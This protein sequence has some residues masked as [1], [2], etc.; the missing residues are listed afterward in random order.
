MAKLLY[1]HKTIKYLF[2]FLLSCLTYQQGLAQ[3]NDSPQLSP[4]ET[5]IYQE[6]KALAQSGKT[7]KSI[8]LFNKLLKIKPDFTEGYLRLGSQYF[9]LQNYTQAKTAFIKAIE[10]NPSFNPEMYY[11]IAQTEKALKNY[12]QAAVYLDQFINTSDNAQK[13]EKAKKMKVNCLFIDHA[14][15]HPVPFHPVGAG[16][17]INTAHSEY[18]PLISVDGQH[19]VFTRNIQNPG[20]FIGQEDIYIA[21]KDS[22]TWINARPMSGVNTVGNEGAFAISGDGYYIVFAACDRRESYGSCDL[23]YSMFM[24]NE[25]TKPVNMGKVVNSV[26]WDSHPTLSADGRTMIFSSR[27]KGSVGGADLWMTQKDEKNS[28][29]TPW[30][31]GSVLN[32]TGDDESP[33]LH[34]DGQTLYFRS[35]GHPG[36]GGFDIFYSRF[37]TYNNTWSTPINIGFP[38]NTEGDEGSLSVSSDGKT[39]WFASNTNYNDNT[40]LKNINI[41]SFELYENARPVPTTYVKGYIQDINTQKPLAGDVELMDLITNKT[42]FKTTTANDGFFI[43][44]LPSGQQYA[45]KVNASGY[46]FFSQHFDLQKEDFTFQPY[47]LNID[48]IPVV[49]DTIFSDNYSMVLHNIFFETGSSVLQP[50]SD[51]EINNVVKMMLDHP[52]FVIKIVG[53]T[54]NIGSEKGNLILSEARAKAVTD[55]LINKNINANR[56][57]YEG[58]GA[59]EPIADNTSEAGRQQNRRTELKFVKL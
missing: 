49:K 22:T 10:L 17:I 21:Q 37:D 16:P 3:I 36:M 2:V 45:C 38:I 6:A 12:A 9:V 47:I 40:L 48:L 11:S 26:T 18:S 43:A 13:I 44:P 57:L 33:F 50:T 51:F 42:L 7:A 52:S 34:P 59:T 46:I 53:H 23:Y 25:W 15:K 27:R 19:L 29:M 14:I 31:L 41:Y 1:I 5:K 32:S 55:A 54:D 20:D 24:D 35:D 58:K 4:K 56:I 30:N 8:V 39:A 28:W